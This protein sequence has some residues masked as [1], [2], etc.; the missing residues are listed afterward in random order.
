MQKLII[1]PYQTYM[2]L[3]FPIKIS[4]TS[5]PTIYMGGQSRNS[6]QNMV[7]ASSVK[8]RLGDL[9]GDDEDG[10]IYEVDL[11]YPTGLHNS[12]DDYPL[13]PES[14]VIDRAMYSPTQQFSIPRICTSEET[15]TESEG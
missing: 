1:L 11:H 6:Y 12:H 15:D 5:M 14:L 4:F 8:M 10:Y 2:I 7:F 13:A 3:T 9:S